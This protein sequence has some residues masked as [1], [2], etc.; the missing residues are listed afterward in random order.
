MARAACPDARRSALRHNGSWLHLLRLSGQLAGVAGV[1]L[2]RPENALD[3]RARGDG[4]AGELVELAAVLLHR[5]ARERRVAQRQAGETRD[6]VA[7]GRFD[8]VGQAGSLLVA[9]HAHAEDP[10]L[11]V[12]RDE[13]DDRPAIAKRADPQ[14]AWLW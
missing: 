7:L 1:Q 3:H 4:G 14:R 11:V 10:S 6:P 9:E 13:L 12:Q 5:P 2:Q 8:L